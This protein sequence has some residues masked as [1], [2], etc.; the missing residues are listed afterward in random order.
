MVYSYND[1][2]Y[3]FNKLN[4]ITDKNHIRD[5]IKIIMFKNS[6]CI[7]EQEKG[8]YIK[9][10]TLTDDTFKELEQYITNIH[11]DNKINDTT[12]SFNEFM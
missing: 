11:Y 4:K 8:T 1:K 9:F 3:L 10:N 2:A 6:N 12:K 7:I 5:I